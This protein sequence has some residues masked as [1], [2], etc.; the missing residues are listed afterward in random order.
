MSHIRPGLRGGRQNCGEGRGVQS[1][2]AGE[3]VDEKEDGAL[4]GRGRAHD[5]WDCWDLSRWETGV[6][7]L[8]F[9]FQVRRVS[10]GLL[11]GWWYC[12]LFKILI[13]TLHFLFLYTEKQIDFFI[14]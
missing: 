3:G 14:F 4:I 2:T 7:G 11:E 5:C 1:K 10:M 13:N 6:G 8:T 9:V 12:Q